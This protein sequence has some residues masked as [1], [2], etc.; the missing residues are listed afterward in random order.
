MDV[1]VGSK[2]GRAFIVAEVPALV[3]HPAS[4][5]ELHRKNDGCATCYTT[6]NHL[7]RA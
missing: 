2:S 7:K 6:L 5:V 1:N 3:S 4:A